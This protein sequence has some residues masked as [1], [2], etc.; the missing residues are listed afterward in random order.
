MK[1]IRAAGPAM[2]VQDGIVCRRFHTRTLQLYP[3]EPRIT[4][5]ILPWQKRCDR[6]AALWRRHTG[7]QGDGQGFPAHRF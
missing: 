4:A 2:R 7:V 3:H 5:R 6:I 1:S